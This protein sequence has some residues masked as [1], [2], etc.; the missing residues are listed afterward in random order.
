MSPAANSEPVKRDQLWLFMAAQ[1]FA[2]ISPDMHD[3][4]LLEYQLPIL[5]KFALTAYGC[6][7]DL[8]QKIDI[9]RRIPNLRRIAVTPWIVL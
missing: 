3:E 1:E 8:T 2:L 4:F 7:E 9:L 5:K 6:C